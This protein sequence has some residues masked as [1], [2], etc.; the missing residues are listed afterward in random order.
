MALPTAA[1]AGRRMAQ[2]LLQNQFMLVL[3]LQVLEHVFV[4]PGVQA[5]LGCPP[6]DFILAWLYSR[7]HPD[8]APLL[9][10][11]TSSPPT[12]ACATRPANT[13]ACCATTFRSTSA[14]MVRPP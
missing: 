12:T 1:E 11:A 8:D 14:P 4:S 9:G 7:V 10:Q 5:L 2:Y 13:C 3:D 6:A